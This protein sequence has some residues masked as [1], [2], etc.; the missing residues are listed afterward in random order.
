MLPAPS[1]ATERR[2]V[3][4][5]SSD[6]GREATRRLPGLLSHCAQRTPSRSNC[7]RAIAANSSLAEIH[8]IACA[9]KPSSDGVAENARTNGAPSSVSPA[10]ARRPWPKAMSV[11]GNGSSME[12]R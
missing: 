1:V 12:K 5:K 11:A 7:R 3:M 2:T 8:F 6:P 9:T 4:R 10:S